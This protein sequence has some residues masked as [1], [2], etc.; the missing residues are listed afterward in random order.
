MGQMTGAMGRV[1]QAAEGTSEIVRDI[2]EIAFQTNLLALNA[3]VE[4]ARAGE[5]GRSFAVVAGEVRSLAMRA[6]E[7]AVRTEALIQESVRQAGEGVETARQVTDRLSRILEAAMQVSDAA[8]GIASASR[9]QALGIEQVSRAVAEMDHVTQQNSSASEESSSSAEE[10]AEQALRLAATVGSFRVVPGPG[11]VM[12]PRS[13][14]KGGGWLPA[15]PSSSPG[16]TPPPSG[17]PAPA[18]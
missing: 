18:P 16:P 11:E 10:L 14:A 7:A 5:A 13:S 3:A 12:G 17:W 4:A 6:K 1:R 15:S 2:S 8:G 9:E